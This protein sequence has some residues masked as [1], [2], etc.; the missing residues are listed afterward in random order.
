[1]I[2][3]PVSSISPCSPLPSGTLRTPGLFIPCCCLPTSSSACLDFFPLSLRLVRWFWPD[4]MNGKHDHTTAVCVFCLVIRFYDWNRAV[5]SL[6]RH[7]CPSLTETASAMKIC[8]LCSLLALYELKQC[9]ES[10][11][12]SPF[13]AKQVHQWQQQKCLTSKQSLRPVSFQ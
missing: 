3:Q 8:S 1:M 10:T 12:L 9:L 6:S 4:L 11:A 5:C 13:S 2:S 7:S